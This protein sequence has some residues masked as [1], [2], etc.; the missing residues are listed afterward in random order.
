[1]G[2]VRKGFEITTEFIDDP[3]NRNTRIFLNGHQN[4]YPPMIG[5][6]FEISLELL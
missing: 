2:V 5:R 3:F 4:G 1:M 6:S